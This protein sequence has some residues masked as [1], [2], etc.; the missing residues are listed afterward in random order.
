MKRLVLALIL[1]VP[2]FGAAT[3][4]DAALEFNPWPNCLPCP[5]P[6][7]D[8]TTPTSRDQMTVNYELALP[9]VR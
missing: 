2:S 1:I 5:R 8:T 6:T 7:E 4:P 3:L 9:E